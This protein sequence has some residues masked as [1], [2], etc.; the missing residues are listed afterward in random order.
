MLNIGRDATVL[1]V[2]IAGTGYISQVFVQ[3]ASQIPDFQ[4]TSVYSREL[5]KAE[6]FASDNLIAQSFSD[7]EDMVSDCDLIYLGIP[8]HLHCKYA[9]QVLEKGKTA[10]V[11]K[12][13]VSN[14]RELEELLETAGNNQSKFFEIS[15]VPYLPNYKILKNALVDIGTIKMVSLNYSQYSRRYQDLLSGNIP[16]IFS[17]EY[18]GGALMDL[19][20]YGVYLIVGLFSAPAKVRYYANQLS[21]GIDSSGNL[22][23][24]YP[25]MLA[26]L[27]FAKDSHSMPFI[28]LQGEDGSIQI[29]SNPL[30]LTPIYCKKNGIETEIGVE[31][32]DSSFVYN[33]MEVSRVI[34]EKDEKAYEE[35]LQLSKQVMMVLE[36][37]R[38]YAGIVF[39]SD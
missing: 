29:N 27:L 18:S 23:L 6:K 11:E 8:N 13:L 33:I 14:M 5:W 38:Q 25:D 30:R 26:S 35:M 31:Q 15:R 17:P 36:Q 22:I 3:V 21:N 7:F 16:H 19:G 1:K 10:L 32:F 24:Q 20:V 2:G 34:R 39:D 9:K 12:P 37:A 28:T 4:I